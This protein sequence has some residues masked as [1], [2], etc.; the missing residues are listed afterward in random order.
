MREWRRAT[1]IGAATLTIAGVIVLL[2]I[3]AAF[4]ATVGDDPPT[5]GGGTSTDTGGGSSGGGTSTDTGGG[6][7]PPPT[8]T[9]NRS[10][11]APNG[12]NG[13]YTS[14]VAISI[15]ITN[16]GDFTDLRCNLVSGSAPLTLADL[17]AG[18]CNAG[19]FGDDG[20]HTYWAGAID[21]TDNTTTLK[22]VDVNIDRTPPTLAPT[23]STNTILVHQGGVTASPHASDATSGV[24]TQSCGPVDTN[25]AGDHSVTCTAKDKAGNQS[26]ATVHYTVQYRLVDLTLVSVLPLWKAGLTLPVRA[27]LVDANWLPIPDAEAASLA[28]ACRVT[29]AASGAQTL[30]VKCMTY[31]RLDKLW[32]YNWAV[33]KT[34]T[35]HETALI[36]VSYPGTATTTTDTDGFTIFK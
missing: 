12:S 5:S 11:S 6:G 3:G 27:A 21:T 32:A 18:V 9:I 28:S 4:A 23:L 30:P 1:R 31:N 26:Q 2:G 14:P 35:G 29:F 22:S 10:P 20:V 19:T 13:W 33:A 17:P 15:S 34:G 24:D 8:L 16:G 7:S 36:S 25:S